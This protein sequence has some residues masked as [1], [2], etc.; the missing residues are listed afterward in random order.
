MRGEEMDVARVSLSQ[1][2]E[3]VEVLRLSAFD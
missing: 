1:G 3:G 2:A